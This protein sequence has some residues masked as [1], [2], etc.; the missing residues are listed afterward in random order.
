MTFLE[1]FEEI[2]KVSDVDVKF[3]KDFAIQINLTDEDCGGAFYVEH[4]AGVVN[5]EPYDY[6][7]R[8]AMM[9]I[10]SGLLVKI[11]T[12]EIDSIAAFF[13]GKFTIDGNVEAVLELTKIADAVKAK[14]KAE[15]KAKKEAEKKAKEKAKKEA[16]KKAKAEAEK[17]AKAEAEKK[18]KEEA[19][20]KAKKEA[21]KA[22]KE[23]EK[24][25]KEAEKKAK[26]EAEKK[27]KEEAE[28][29]E[30]KKAPAKKAEKK[31]PVKKT[32]KADDKQMKLD[33]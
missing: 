3:D 32:A 10:D 30:V 5:V 21:E 16:E 14:R 15:E 11:L 2:K 27:A 17:K 12:G 23:A 9:T 1:K 20:K 33:I 28:K 6:N 19:E 31:A 26:A 4:R 7:D 8:D 24:A 18:A 29:K 13:A 25:K 22:A